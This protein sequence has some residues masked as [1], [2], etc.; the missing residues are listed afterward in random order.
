MPRL[1]RSVAMAGLVLAVGWIAW[2]QDT[3]GTG[4]KD[5]TAHIGAPVRLETEQG[6]SF[7]GVLRSVQ[8]DRIEIV[9]NDGQILHIDAE[10]LR[11]FVAYDRDASRNTFFMDSASNRLV[12]VPTAFA[13]E[14]GE[15]HVA[16]QEIAVVTMSYGLTEHITLWAG[17]SIPGLV[18][19]ARA[20]AGIAPQLA[21]SVGS[22]AGL[23]WLEDFGSGGVIPYGLASYGEPNNN[24][25]VGCG[26]LFFYNRPQDK[27]LELT[28]VIA[29]LGGK[30]VVS[31]TT[32]LVFENWIVWS[33][34][35]TYS[36]MEPAVDLDEEDYVIDTYWDPIPRF[37]YP[38]V[39][40]RIAGRRFSWDIGAVVPLQITTEE[41]IDVDPETE[42]DPVK[43]YIRNI[44]PRM[45]GV[46]DGTV[47][48]IPIISL[49]YRID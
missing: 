1:I 16:D 8:A 19:N 6:G 14:P 38:A 47:A 46:F 21:V 2:G 9:D 23:S 7:Q 36:T 24:V 48:P 13:M 44:D 31:S 39:C 40:F 30:K 20:T 49:T 27:P 17:T 22:F 5:L 28:G 43:S 11:S 45:Q 4:L 35:D 29:V 41:E 12:V 18:L 25:T 3:Y 37:V 26:P 34:R 42:D 32:S 15:F 33:Q 10:S